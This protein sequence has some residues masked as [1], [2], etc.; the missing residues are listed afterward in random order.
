MICARQGLLT[1]HAWAMIA[2]DRALLW[3]CKGRVRRINVFVYREQ[4]NIEESA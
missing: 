4:C 2:L 3:S 1:S